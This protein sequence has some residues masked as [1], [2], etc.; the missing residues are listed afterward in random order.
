VAV[1]LTKKNV[2]VVEARRLVSRDEE[3]AVAAAAGGSWRKKPEHTDFA[4][5]FDIDSS[6]AAVKLRQD[7]LHYE[8]ASDS[9]LLHVYVENVHLEEPDNGPAR[10]KVRGGVLRNVTA[11]L[12]KLFAKPTESNK[13]QM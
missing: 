13:T 2:V 8:Y 1:R 4:I 12:S 6:G 5:D 11:G 9:G 10:K 7:D 3:A